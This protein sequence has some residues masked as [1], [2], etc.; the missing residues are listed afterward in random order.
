MSAT[1]NPPRRHWDRDAPL[2]EAITLWRTGR[3]E[4]TYVPVAALDDLRQQIADEVEAYEQSSD[5]YADAVRRIR[6][7]GSR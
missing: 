7:G 4:Q 5:T 3:G 1:N 2:P 6:E